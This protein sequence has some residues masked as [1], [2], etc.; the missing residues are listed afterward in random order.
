MPC[1][2]LIHARH[3]RTFETGAGAP[4]AW[5]WAAD[6]SKQ[7]HA[8]LFLC[9][10]QGRFV[11]GAAPPNRF[12]GNYCNPLEWYSWATSFSC[13]LLYLRRV[14]DVFTFT[15]TNAPI[16]TPHN[17]TFA[18]KRNWLIVPIIFSSPYTLLIAALA[19]QIAVNTVI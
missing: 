6:N 14:I 17:I 8:S 16:K 18:K 5:S 3:P 9:W 13:F 1:V 2:I 12:P 10:K 11:L 7:F 19:L 4:N 15:I